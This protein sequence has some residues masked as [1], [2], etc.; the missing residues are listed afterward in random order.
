MWLERCDAGASE[1]VALLQPSNWR[2]DQ[3]P[4]QPNNWRDEQTS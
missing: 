4:L 3:T 1:G 2:E